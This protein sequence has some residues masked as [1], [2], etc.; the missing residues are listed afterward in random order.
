MRRG[1]VT[2]PPASAVEVALDET[3]YE[4]TALGIPVVVTPTPTESEDGRPR[5]EP[6]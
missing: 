1:R 5:P 6:R 2:T 3:A 4:E